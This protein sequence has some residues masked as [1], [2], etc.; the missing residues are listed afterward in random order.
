MDELYSVEALAEE[1]NVTT[2][3]IRNYLKEGRLKGKKIGGQWR[4]TAEEVS[5][6][7]GHDRKESLIHHFLEEEKDD[8]RA[9]FIL[10]VPLASIADLEEFVQKVVAHYND[11]YD[12]EKRRFQYQLTEN[13][14]ARFTLI[15]PPPYVLGLANFINKLA[16]EKAIH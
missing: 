16:Q 8:T 7:T 9:L 5:N 15:G 4:F 11:V 6:F 2:R 1:L 3:T 12:G 10:D 13:Q 14:I